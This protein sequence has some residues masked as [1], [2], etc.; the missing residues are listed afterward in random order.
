MTWKRHH[1]HEPLSPSSSHPSLLLPPS[2]PSPPV[3]SL[4]GLN[5]CLAERAMYYPV[6]TTSIYIPTVHHYHL[7]SSTRL[8]LSL[9][10]SSTQRSLSPK[11]SFLKADPYI[12]PAWGNNR[13][14]CCLC[15]WRGVKGTQGQ[16]DSQGETNIII[17]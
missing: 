10:P 5:L 1:R 6:I 16:G 2:S 11:W 14:E 13:T 3:V 8:S 7:L 17:F 12:Y 15:K 9:S 4:T